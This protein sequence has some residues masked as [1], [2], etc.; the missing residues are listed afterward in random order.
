MYPRNLVLGNYF[1]FVK[2]LVW[3]F[4]FVWVWLAFLR[5]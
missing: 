3:R 1:N 5:S 2:I 4:T